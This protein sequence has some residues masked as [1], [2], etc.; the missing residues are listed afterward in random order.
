[1][2]TATVSGL[3]PTG[4]VVF[5]DA[6]TTLATVGLSNGRAKLTINSLTVGQHSYTA[7]YSGDSANAGSTGSLSLS[8]AKASPAMTAAHRPR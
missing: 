1:M 2:L 6:G 4:T 7:Q 3:S 5:A 8:V